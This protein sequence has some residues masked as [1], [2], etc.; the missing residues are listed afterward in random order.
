MKNWLKENLV[1]AVGL[2]L[3]LLLILLFFVASVLPKSM[4][5]PPQHEMLFSTVKYEYQKSPDYMFDFKVKEGKVMVSSKKMDD[6]NN[7]GS[8]TKLMAYDG[9]TETV[10]EITIDNA[11]TG[12]AAVSGETILDETKDLTVDTNATSPDGYVLEGPIYGSSG[13]VGGL[14]GGGYRNSGFR[15]IKGAVAYKIPNL[16]PDYYY[17]NVQFLGWVVSK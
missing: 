13:L 5:I 7:S 12:A 14:F 17:S 3:P 8:S 4:G 15:L 11:K 6:K 1:L 2:T 16:Q 9:K 10:R